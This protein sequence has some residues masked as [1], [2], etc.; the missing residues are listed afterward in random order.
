MEAGCAGAGEDHL[1]VKRAFRAILRPARP[2]RS[3]PSVKCC[4]ARDVTL[5]E[6]SVEPTNPMS[7]A[8][9]AVGDL[10]PAVES[11]PRTKSED[12]IPLQ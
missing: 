1:L 5:P 2:M 9:V 6:K 8:A 11:Q 3:P 4:C 12:S 7:L 10:P